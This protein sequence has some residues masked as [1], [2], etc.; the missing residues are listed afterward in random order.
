M[1]LSYDANLGRMTFSEDNET[2]QRN[3]G[4]PTLGDSF[5]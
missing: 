4:A 2:Q 3:H 5:G 1:I